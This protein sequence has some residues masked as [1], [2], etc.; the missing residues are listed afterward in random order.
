MK[1]WR[2]NSL[3]FDKAKSIDEDWFDMMLCNE[4]V[5]KPLVAM[6]RDLS[7]CRGAEQN[8]RRDALILSRATF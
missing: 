2:S 1:P 8:G 3:V 4:A 6:V 5:D 7:Y